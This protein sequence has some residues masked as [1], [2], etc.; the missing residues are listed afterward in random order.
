LVDVFY[1]HFL[2]KDF[3]R[4]AIISLEDFCEYIYDSLE[5][6]IAELPPRLQQFVPV[7]IGENTLLSYRQLDGI[8]TALTRINYRI[9]KKFSVELAMAILKDL[10]EFIENDFR[11]FFPCLIEATESY[12]KGY[13]TFLLPALSK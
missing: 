10:Y 12:R 6:N 3:G 1:D 2:A 9:K 7:M 8:Q 5:K 13:S 4:I 11:K